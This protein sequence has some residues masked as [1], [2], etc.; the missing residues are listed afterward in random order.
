MRTAIYT[1][2]ILI[3]TFC[4]ADAHWWSRHHAHWHMHHHRHVVRI[5]APMPM[6]RP[7]FLWSMPPSEAYYGASQGYLPGEKEAFIR[8]VQSGG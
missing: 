7:S 2:T 5:A 1:L 4:V 6:T 3:G 8:S